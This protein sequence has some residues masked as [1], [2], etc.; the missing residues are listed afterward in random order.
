MRWYFVGVKVL[1]RWAKRRK[2]E[3][4]KGVADLKAESESF[5]FWGWVTL[6]FGEEWSLSDFCESDGKV[7]ILIF[8][9]NKGV[10][11]EKMKDLR[12]FYK[13]PFLRY[14]C[15]FFKV[16]V[17]LLRLKLIIFCRSRSRPTFWSHGI[18]EYIGGIFRGGAFR[19]QYQTFI[20]RARFF[21]ITLFKFRWH[22]SRSIL[23]T[24]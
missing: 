5:W 15:C 4:S 11:W 19:D 17:K 12:L 2:S 16:E 20:F 3:K 21:M 14:R 1:E 13:G 10:L 24:F 6:V 9:L 23:F 22:S 18:F 7:W 8:K